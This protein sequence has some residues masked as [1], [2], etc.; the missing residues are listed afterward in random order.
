MA[1]EGYF[2]E[3]IAV[4]RE[5]RTLDIASGADS[6]QIRWYD[7]WIESLTDAAAL[8]DSA[9]RELAQAN[10]LQF[11][12][13]D[14]W[15]QG[16]YMQALGW[17]EEQLRLRQRW[18]GP[19][20]PETAYALGSLGRA[21]YR[22]GGPWE[23]EAPIRES[24]RILR[25]RFGSDHF[26]TL[27]TQ[28]FLAELLE[29]Q[30]SYEEAEELLRSVIAARRR[31]TGQSDPSLAASLNSLADVYRRLG[32]LQEAEHVLREALHINRTAEY[33]WIPGEEKFRR[34]QEADLERELAEVLLDEGDAAEASAHAALALRT[35][36]KF[37]EE[38]PVIATMLATLGD[39][40]AE[41]GHLERADSLLE[42]V[43]SIRR[44]YF[45]PRHRLL[46]AAL[47]SV[48]RLREREGRL[49]EAAAI[50]A[51]SETIQREVFGPHHP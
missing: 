23:A 12:I 38:P 15:D 8:P 37:H 22:V 2:E 26:L 4:A 42:A 20:H 30:G 1:T 35:R 17:T 32:K 19:D 31:R 28:T 39:A 18:F 13:G 3:A 7:V 41:L 14:A 5:L 43:V 33:E 24:V 49:E 10:Q 50:Y 40:E 51:E 48:G 36:R 47:G 27:G 34:D 21:L 6:A 11:E 46:A 16:H 29:G 25:D 44:E 45:G 9:R